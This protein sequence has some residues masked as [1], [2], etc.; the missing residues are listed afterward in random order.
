MDQPYPAF[1]DPATLAR[2]TIF[3]N[4]IVLGGHTTTLDDVTRI[5]ASGPQNQTETDILNYWNANQGSSNRFKTARAVVGGFIAFAGIGAA[6]S[7]L[8]GQ[9]TAAAGGIKTAAVTTKLTSGYEY[10]AGASLAS[11]APVAAS[12]T[13]A[14]IFGTAT[15]G[16]KAVTLSSLVK[17]WGGAAL[18]VLSGATKPSNEAE[19]NMTPPFNNRDLFADYGSGY[20]EGGGYGGGALLNTQGEEISLLD[21]LTSN[22]LYVWLIGGIL[23]VVGFL[24]FVRR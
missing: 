20:G 3:T 15:S 10:L 22:P 8:S 19:A 14:G 9:A 11:P 23:L 18:K 16:A 21:S 17:D 13:L 1:A 6:A 4:P 7:V 24:F 12:P 2:G 5:K